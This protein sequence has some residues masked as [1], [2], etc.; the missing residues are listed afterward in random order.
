VVLFG[1]QLTS[2]LLANKELNFGPLLRYRGERDDVDNN[3]V[4]DMDK[5]DAAVELGAFVSLKIDKFKL[6]LNGAQ[7]VSDSHDGYVIEF[8]GSY[9]HSFNPDLA[10]V[11][12]AGTSYASDDYMET[13]FGV[14]GG[15][16]GSSTLDNF[17]IDGGMKDVN[18]SATLVQ[19]IS[20]TWEL[21]YLVKYTAILEDAKDSPIVDDE[22]DSNQYFGGITASYHF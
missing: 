14:D 7:D 16:R 13:Y 20:E 2:N 19:K 4:D 18:I 6:E 22:G 8:K 12:G 3:E 1:N 10:L 11:L 21:M 5:V 9:T 17:D 15:N